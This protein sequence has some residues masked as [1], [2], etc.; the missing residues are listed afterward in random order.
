MLLIVEGERREVELFEKLFSIYDLDSNYEIY[1]YQTNIHELYERMFSGGDPHSYSLLGMLKER[2]RFQDRH[3]FDQ[4]YSD[5]LLVF[6]YDPQDNR[7]TASGLRELQEYFCESTDEGQL[8]INYPMVEA[9]K[10]FY[11]MPDYG[12]LGR[13]VSVADLPNYKT[14]V[15]NESAFQSFTRDLDKDAVNQIVALVAAKACMLVGVG[16]D[17]RETAECYSRLNHTDILDEQNRRLM[18]CG[19]ISVLG[20]CILF[21]ADYSRELAN[22]DWI[23][24]RLFG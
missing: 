3:I 14:R 7:F 18:E 2:A 13:S 21:V 15:A 23:V 6:D 16:E 1:P 12:F 10:H 24:R 5:V 17:P 4:E 9:C 22:L 20:T 11:E 8:Y 19:E